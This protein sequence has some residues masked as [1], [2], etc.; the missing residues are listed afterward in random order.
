MNRVQVLDMTNTEFCDFIIE[1][2]KLSTLEEKQV[3]AKKFYDKMI[4]KYGNQFTKDSQIDELIK[5]L[6][7]LKSY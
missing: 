3:Y 2:Y 6:N 1:L 7:D 4:N 5:I